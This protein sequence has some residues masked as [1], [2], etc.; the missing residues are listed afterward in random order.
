[1]S[2]ERPTDNIEDRLRRVRYFR[3][4]GM[5]HG[6]RADPMENSLLAFVYDI[7]YFGACGVFPPFHL[8]NQQLRRGGSHG[9]MSPGA[10]WEP[11]ELSP[12]EY[13]DLVEAVRTVPPESVRDRARYA[14]LAFTF[15]PAFDGRLETYPVRA[16]PQK[17]HQRLPADLKE[18]AEWAGAVCSKHRE[19][20]E[21]DMKRA[22]FRR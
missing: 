6:D 10:T 7:P 13:R 15:D 21:A 16:E 8:L 22:G 4:H 19:R 18:H 2:Q 20:W 12:E 5:W 14:H 1:M 3:H 11:F 9:G 17:W